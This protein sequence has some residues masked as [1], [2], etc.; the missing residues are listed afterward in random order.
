M[1]RSMF[2]QASE[3]VS[4]QVKVGMVNLDITTVL[5]AAVVVGVIGLLIG[6]LLGYAGKKF[7]VEI[8][9]RE[10]RVRAALPG[11][12]CGGCGYAGCDG[13]AKAIVAGE[14]SVDA[15]PVGG[16][17]V[18]AEVGAIMGVEA[19]G[20]IRKVAF[21]ACGG[22]CDVTR[23]K[24]TYSGVEDC[25]AAMVVPGA[26][27]KL[28]SYGCLGFGSCVRACPFEAIHIVGGIAKVDE[29]KCKACSKCVAACPK[30][31]IS[32]IPESQPVRVKCSSPER[33]K[34]VMQACDVGCRGC[35]LCAKVCPQKAIT[36]ENNLPVVNPELCEGC[37]VCAEKCP[38][39]T[40]SKKA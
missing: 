33:A 34:Q 14:A 10:E 28:C 37:F 22:T 27:D 11:N 19:A 23:T 12:N 36:M 3:A 29:D 8:D 30:H 13:L 40:I 32:L 4:G 2:L 25:A 6:L 16:A 7:A 38:A 21:V 31:L 39:H 9:A 20:G 35:T 5:L 24:Y 26:G 17:S 1:N 18:A 15:C